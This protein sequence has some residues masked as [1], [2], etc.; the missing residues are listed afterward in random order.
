VSILVGF[1]LAVQRLPIPLSWFGVGLGIW[2]VS[3]SDSDTSE[4]AWRIAF[5]LGKS[6][7]NRDRFFCIISNKISDSRYIG[8]FASFSGCL[9]SLNLVF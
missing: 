9:V 6:K 5:C 7:S 1:I 8:I 3:S 2:E 4:F